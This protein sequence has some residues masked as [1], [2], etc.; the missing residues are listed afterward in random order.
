MYP[1]PQTAFLALSWGVLQAFAVGTARVVNNCGFPVW[2]ASIAQDVHAPMQQLP[3]EGF[4]QAYSLAG[5][6]VSVK[7]AQNATGPVTQFEYTWSDGKVYYDISH[8]DGNPFAVVGTSL[9]PSG[10]RRADFPT[11]KTVEC[12]PCSGSTAQ[13]YCDDAYNQ[14]DDVRTMV[15]PEDTDLTM[16]LCVDTL[17]QRG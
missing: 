11:C 12:P 8:I 6:G 10:T 16:T 14:P 4:Q 9:S 17:T 15:C 1:S 5:I 7:L 3:L 2:Y 13:C